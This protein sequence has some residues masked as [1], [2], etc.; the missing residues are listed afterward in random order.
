MA[1]I[2]EVLGEMFLEEVQPTEEQ[3]IVSTLFID[4]VSDSTMYGITQSVGILAPKPSLRA[5]CLL[6]NQC[7][8]MQLWRKKRRAQWI[9]VSGPL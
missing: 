4:T 3:L 5:N 8:G 7:R 2:D 9:A 6:W 1:N